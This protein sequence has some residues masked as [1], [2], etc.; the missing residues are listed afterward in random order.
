MRV[1]LSAERVCISL[2]QAV[3]VDEMASLHTQSQ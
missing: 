3:Y 2:I 1:A